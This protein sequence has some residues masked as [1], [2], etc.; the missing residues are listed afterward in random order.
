LSFPSGVVRG[1]YSR[2][3]ILLDLL[4]HETIERGI[5]DVRL[6]TLLRTDISEAWVGHFMGDKQSVLAALIAVRIRV[7]NSRDRYLI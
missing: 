3:F 6:E 1:F 2:I 7:S 4:D 5:N